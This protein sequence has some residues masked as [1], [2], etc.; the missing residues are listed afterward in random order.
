MCVC[1]ASLILQYLEVR[2][3]NRDCR[4][5][6]SAKTTPPGHHAPLERTISRKRWRPQT[7]HSKKT[8]SVSS[9]LQLCQAC[10]ERVDDSD[11]VA[12]LLEAG[13]SVNYAVTQRENITPLLLA[14][15]K[16][17][18]EISQ[19]LVWANADLTASTSDGCTALHMLAESDTND[20]AGARLVRMLCSVEGYG[21]MEV[22]GL[23]RVESV[24]ESRD[25]NGTQKSEV[26]QCNQNERTARTL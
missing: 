11:A 22:A 13:A 3:A 7:P 25:C 20:P 17:H 5:G 21:P 2:V 1:H 26:H 8:P 4:S 16:R 23:E 18:E 15:N 12:R 19:L 10:N 24:L 14:L 9:T 6:I